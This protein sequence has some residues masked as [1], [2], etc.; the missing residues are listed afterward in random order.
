MDKYFQKDYDP[1][2][3]ITPQTDEKGFIVDS[4][5]W[6]SM[7]EAVR[8]RAQRK[9]ETRSYKHNRDDS[10]HTSSKAAP[11]P[12]MALQYSKGPREWDK[13]KPTK[14]DGKWEPPT[15]T[16]IK[17]KNTTDDLT[18]YKDSIGGDW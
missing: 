15:Q 11:H 9:E 18:L 7:L 8:E 13:G 12:A 6:D 14:V 1:R 4:G 3:D 17:A 5:E 2:L 10:H 16:F